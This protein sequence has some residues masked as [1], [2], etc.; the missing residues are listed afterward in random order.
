MAT[1]TAEFVIEHEASQVTATSVPQLNWHGT[2]TLSNF[3][4]IGGWPGGL[5]I[6]RGMGQKRTF[7]SSA[8]M[9]NYASWQRSADRAWVARALLEGVWR[10]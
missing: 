7:S 6:S 2:V 4:W 1:T 8:A 5:H 3:G 10:A 9:H